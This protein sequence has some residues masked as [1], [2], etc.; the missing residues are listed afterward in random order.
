MW[1]YSHQI[2]HLKTDLDQ[3]LSES[4][5]RLGVDYVD[6]YWLH[7]DEPARAIGDIVE[8]LAG[9]VRDGRIRSYGGSNWSVAR[10]EEAN[11]YAADHGLPPFVGSQ[12]G[13]A[14]ADLTCVSDLSS[15]SY[16]T[17]LSTRTADINLAP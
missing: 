13:W 17:T 5:D 7:R 3:D 4:L 14:L 6:V 16:T 1:Y 12:P 15:S 2:P 9:F 11:T 8:S 10:F